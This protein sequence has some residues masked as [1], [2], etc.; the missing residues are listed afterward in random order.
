[1]KECILDIVR[2]G[3]GSDPVLSD[4]RLEVGRGG[5]LLLVGGNGAG[6]STC[7]KAA[8]GR[9]PQVKG[10]LLLGDRRIEL[11]TGYKAVEFGVSY[12]PQGSV[13]FPSLT[14]EENVHAA[15]FGLTSS[16]RERRFGM[17]CDLLPD[18]RRLAHRRGS[19]LSAGQRQIV[20]LAATLSRF[21]KLALLDEPC[22]GLDSIASDYIVQ[23]IEEMRSVFGMTVMVAEHRS[24]IFS[25]SASVT[26]GL[27]R[28][29]VVFCGA[30]ESLGKE[31]VLDSIFGI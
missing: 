5:L 21:P 14:V 12:L 28:G 16:A 17:I 9:V 11:N 15:L 19:Q 13:I 7:L 23:T 2:A 10:E 27:R 26:I 24:E 18:V 31:E 3:Y 30:G 8:I 25:R 1:M 22:A 4:L 20:G 6:K 29:E